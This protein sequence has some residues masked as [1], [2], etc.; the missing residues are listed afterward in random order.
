M[1]PLWRVAAGNVQNKLCVIRLLARN[2]SYFLD[3]MEG[4]FNKRARPTQLPHFRSSHIHVSLQYIWMVRILFPLNVCSHPPLFTFDT[5]SQTCRKKTDS[6]ST[7]ST[8]PRNVVKKGDGHVIWDKGWMHWALCSE[9]RQRM[10]E[11]A[12]LT[13]SMYV[14]KVFVRNG[15]DKKE[16]PV[17]HSVLLCSFL[18]CGLL[19]AMWTDLSWPEW[20]SEMAWG[21][22]W[23]RPTSR[24]HFYSQL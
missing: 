21:R 1:L 19:S 3:D 5:H 15:Y 23:R 24:E 14:T 12:F 13:G 2:V 10:R 17:G 16:H 4:I 20:L 22:V 8:T 11:W 9:T 6:S 18:W 7:D